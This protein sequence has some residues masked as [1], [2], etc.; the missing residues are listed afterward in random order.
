MLTKFF[1]G[2]F[3]CTFLHI[4]RIPV[5]LRGYYQP[6]CGYCMFVHKPPKCAPSSHSPLVSQSQGMTDAVNSCIVL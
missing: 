5:R 2:D 4:W 6:G 1:K 3:G